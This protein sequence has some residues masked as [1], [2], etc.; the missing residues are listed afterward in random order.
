MFVATWYN[1]TKKT[2][3][4]LV[5]V[6]PVV[7]VNYNRIFEMKS[8]VAITS[9]GGLQQRVLVCASLTDSLT[10]AAASLVRARLP[11]AC[12]SLIMPCCRAACDVNAPSVVDT[13]AFITSFNLIASTSSIHQLLHQTHQLL[14]TLKCHSSHRPRRLLRTMPRK[15]QTGAHILHPFHFLTLN[16]RFFSA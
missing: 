8:C 4:V 14:L 11:A 13:I 1:S 9:A 16:M 5:P 3:L 15:L 7:L 6:L 12:S 2:S 10:A